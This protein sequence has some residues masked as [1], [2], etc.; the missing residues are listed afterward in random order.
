MTPLGTACQ[1]GGALPVPNE[2]RLQGQLTAP[3]LLT[4][5]SC[6]RHPPSPRSHTAGQTVLTRAWIC[7]PTSGLL[8]RHV[9]EGQTWLSGMGGAPRVKEGWSEG[10][11]PPSTQAQ[12][13]T[14]VG[15]CGTGLTDTESSPQGAEAPTG[16]R[17]LEALKE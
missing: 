3:A 14:G 13:S 12:S 7:P 15:P 16:A 11:R 17:T 5:T 10:H 1:L 9:K 4:L 8:R 6:V 2:R